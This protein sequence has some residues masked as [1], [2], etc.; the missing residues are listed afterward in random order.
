M[1][2]KLWKVLWSPNICSVCRVTLI[3]VLKWYSSMVNPYQMV[4][5]PFTLWAGATLVN[6]GSVQVPWIQWVRF[7]CSTTISP[8][9]PFSLALSSSPTWEQWRVRPHLV[10]RL[11]WI[12]RML[13]SRVSYWF[14]FDWSFYST[15]D[16]DE[17]CLKEW[18]IQ[19]GIVVP[20]WRSAWCHC[21]SHLYSVA[22]WI[23]WSLVTSSELVWPSAK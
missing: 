3:W 18:L 10:I 21:H 12:R 7:T 22:S 16:N 17:I 20:W 11:I 23:T 19:I 9:R 5:W 14:K 8:H 2:F 15:F 6:S 13:H 4:A 1:I